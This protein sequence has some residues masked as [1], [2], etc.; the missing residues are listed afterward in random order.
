[1]DNSEIIKLANK[2]AKGKRPF[3][4]D[5]PA[6]ERVLSVTMAIA[7]EL[8]VTRERLDTVERLLEQKKP[9][10]KKNI[11]NYLATDEIAKERQEWQSD[12]IARILRIF[13]QE[14]DAAREKDTD[15]ESEK[16]ADDQLKK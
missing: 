11:D 3:F 16:L 13:H 5:D 12:Y 9:I 7:T 4:L 6:V 2:K 15:K 1:M 10:T 14:I 8:A